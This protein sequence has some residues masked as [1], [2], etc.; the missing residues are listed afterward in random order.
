MGMSPTYVG[1][2]SSSRDPGG[3]ERDEAWVAANRDL[4]ISEG[5]RACRWLGRRPDVPEID[6]SGESTVDQLSRRYVTHAK[7]THPLP[8][9]ESGRS[10][11][12]AGA[13][14]R[15][16]GSTREDKTAPQ[17]TEED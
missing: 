2:W 17:T 11:V 10:F 15:L 5:K 1:G 13:W 7:A 8:L 16:C 14:S 12:T 3:P 6:P 9:S 4:V